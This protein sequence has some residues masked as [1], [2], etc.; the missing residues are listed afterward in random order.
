VTFAIVSVL[1]VIVLV[2]VDITVHVAKRPPRSSERDDGKIIV[3]LT[4]RK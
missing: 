1:V 2:G 3:D 4:K